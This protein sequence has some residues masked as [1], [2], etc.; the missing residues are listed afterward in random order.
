MIAADV[1]AAA[2]LHRRDDLLAVLGR[3]DPLDLPDVGLDTGVLELVDRLDHQLGA[4]L[5][6]VPLLVA[7]DLLELGLLGGHQELEHELAR[8]A[9]V[10]VVGEPLQPLR[11]APVQ[12]RVAFGVVAHQDLAERRAELL[13]VGGEVL[14]VLEVE[15]VLAALLGR[16]GRVVAVLRRVV[17]DLGAE[18]LVHQDAG[19]VLRDPPASASLK[20]S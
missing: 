3:I 6:V 9:G 20:P 4:E 1:V 13:D 19:L 17:Q 10:Q 7:A 2:A 15:L 16:A 18:L 12:R 11:L 14:A 8:A 5:A